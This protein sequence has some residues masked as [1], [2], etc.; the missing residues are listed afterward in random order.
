MCG[1]SAKCSG[2]QICQ[3]DGTCCL[4]ETADLQA[5]IN[6][7]ETNATLVLC[8]GTW[9]LSGTIDIVKNLTLIG[10]GAGKTILDGGR[11]VRVLQIREMSGRGATV[12]LQ[13][14]TIT[15]GRADTNGGISNQ[16]TL[17]LRG[18][19][20][21]GNTTNPVDGGMYSYT[22]GGIYNGEYG[23]LTL[24]D[25]SRVTGNAAYYGSGIYNQRGGTVTLQEGTVVC[26][27]TPSGSDNECYNEGTLIGAC[28]HCHS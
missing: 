12:T 23:L 4:P 26:G 19:D 18:V 15:K 13:D 3:T 27:N 28:P 21:T 11:S 5:A 20:V 17:T 2:G 6:G 7:A 14:L 25:G 16:G 1:G 8:A 24:Q 22:G 9:N 10:A